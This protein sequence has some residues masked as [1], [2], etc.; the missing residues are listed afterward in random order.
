MVDGDAEQ[1]VLVPEPVHDGAEQQSAVEVGVAAEVRTGPPQG[2]VQPLRL[3]QVPQVLLVRYEGPGRPDLLASGLAALRERHAQCL[4]AGDERGQRRVQRVGPQR[5][6]EPE[7]PAD[8]ADLD[9][10]AALLHPLLN[11]QAVRLVGQQRKPFERASLVHG[12]HV[13]SP[14]GK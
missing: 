5:S 10:Q 8:H 3:G 4:V 6:G 2:L 1:M 9:A 7:H 11:R 14:S 13:N 12:V